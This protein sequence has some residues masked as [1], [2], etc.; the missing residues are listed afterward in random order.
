MPVIGDSTEELPR[1]S[2]WTDE[3]RDLWI[4]LMSA[5]S[6]QLMQ[7]ELDRSLSNSSGRKE[8][9]VKLGARLADIA[10]QEYQFRLYQQSETHPVGDPVER[11][12]E[13]SEWLDKRIAPRTKRP[14]RRKQ[15]V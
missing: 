8:D 2:P 11:F 6:Q 12:A 9:A 3:E 1:L 4:D 15:R 13:F 7:S 14:I 5:Y 10:V